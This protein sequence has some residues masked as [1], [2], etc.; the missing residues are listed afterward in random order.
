[1]ATHIGMADRYVIPGAEHW[2]NLEHREFFLKGLRLAA[3]EAI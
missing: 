1:M 3:G 2:R